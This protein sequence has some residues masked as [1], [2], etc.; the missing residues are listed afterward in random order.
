M[1]KGI[2]SEVGEGIR[3]A[4]IQP[5]NGGDPVLVLDK[6][7][8]KTVSGKECERQR[9]EYNLVKVAEAWKVEAKNVKFI[10]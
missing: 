6:Q 2:L 9:V 5:D 8:L 1:E 7:F 10:Y 4:W 3:M